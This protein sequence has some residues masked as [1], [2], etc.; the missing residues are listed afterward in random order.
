NDPG[1]E[2]SWRTTRR[3]WLTAGLLVGSV[4]SA[5][6]CPTDPGDDDDDNEP[7]PSDP[8]PSK[9]ERMLVDRATYGRNL[10]ELARVEQMGYEGYLEY[11][12]DYTNIPDN[13]VNAKLGQFPTLNMTP[14]Q[15][16]DRFTSGKNDAIDDLVA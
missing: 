16:L 9:V 7:P 2:E 8:N 11:Q 13:A 15:I 4:L 3:D 14:K 12:L 10:E 1:E 6:G 5:S